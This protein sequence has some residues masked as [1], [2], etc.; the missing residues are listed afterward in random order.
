MTKLLLASGLALAAIVRADL[1][2]AQLAGC[3]STT[4]GQAQI[5]NNVTNPITTTTT[6]TTTIANRINAALQGS[7][8]NAG[9]LSQTTTNTS[10][11]ANITG[12]AGSSF[13]TA[14]LT[15]NTNSQYPTQ[16]S[17]GGAVVMSNSIGGQ[18]LIQANQNTGTNAVQQNS[19]GLTSAVGGNGGGLSGFSPAITSSIR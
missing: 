2:Q 6:N 9:T 19:V 14:N 12:G 8:L 18:G 16:S 10:T 4:C 17:I 1:A 15:N 13:N 5:Q 11:W 3:T 7:V